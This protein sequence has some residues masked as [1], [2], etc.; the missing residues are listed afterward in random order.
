MRGGV[1]L[2]SWLAVPGGAVWEWLRCRVG[3]AK[4]C[5]LGESEVTG[6]WGADVERCG[7]ASGGVPGR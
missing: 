3:D 5:G 2:G 1:G 7:L 4:R 6:Q